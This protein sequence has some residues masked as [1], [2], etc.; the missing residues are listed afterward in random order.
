MS[1]LKCKKNQDEKY[2]TPKKSGQILQ[3]PFFIIK[4]NSDNFQISHDSVFILRFC[5]DLPQP[6]I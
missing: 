6:E 4:K 1:K 3:A 2:M 5:F